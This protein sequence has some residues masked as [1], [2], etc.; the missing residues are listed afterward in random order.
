M[1]VVD[2]F[3]HTGEPSGDDMDPW[4]KE[5]AI[6]RI[7]HGALAHLDQLVAWVAWLDLAKGLSTSFDRKLDAAIG[8]LIAH[9][10]G[11]RSDALRHLAAFE[12]E[13]EAQR[14]KGLTD[15]EADFL[16]WALDLVLAR[17]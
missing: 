1:F 5:R 3:L 14:G 16:L 8:A 15:R 6:V 13:V 17:L 9:T 11:Y 4:I 10:N 7:D 12:S 2:A